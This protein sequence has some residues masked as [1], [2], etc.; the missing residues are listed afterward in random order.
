MN[1]ARQVLKTYFGYDA[2][3]PGQ[4]E[5]IESILAHRDVLAVMPTGA[6]KSL[7]YQI[8]A[9]L[10]E[11]VTVVISP[12]ISLMKDQV[13]ALEA[14][15]IPTTFINSTH[16]LPEIQQRTRGLRQGK[17]RL[18][19][20]APER[21]ESAF[22][23]ELLAS[24]TIPLVAVDEAHCVSQ[25]GHDFRP[26]YMH[27]AASI[28]KLPS[29]PIIAAFTATA[30]DRVKQDIAEGLQ[31]HD[32]LRVTTGYA[33]ENLTF[34]VFRGVDK[35]SFLLDYVR[36]HADESGIIYASTRKEVEEC[37]RYLNQ[38]GLAAGV[39]HAGIEDEARL[40]AQEQFLY[41]RISVMV[42]TNA[43]GMGI[44]KSNVRYVLHY[45]MPRNIESYYQEAGRAGRD[46]DAGDCILLYGPQ[47]VMTQKYIIEQSETDEER[48]KSEYRNLHQM[49]EY[50]HTSHCLQQHIVYYFGDRTA[51]P[52][53]KCSNCT[54]D[55]ETVDVTTEAQKI[56]SC[57]VKMKQRFG[58]TLTAKVLR[59]ANDQKVRQ[60]GLSQLSTYGI[61]S[62]YKEKELVQL[63]QS[64]IVDGYL[65]LSDSAYPVLQITAKAKSVLLSDEK[66]YMKRVVQ[67]VVTQSDYAVVNESLFEELRSLRKTLSQQYRIPPFTIFHDATL[68]EMSERLP[69]SKADM[70]D[71]KGMG[72]V[73]LE[74]YGDDFLE[75]IRRFRQ[76]AP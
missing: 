3:R 33:R 53:G 24:L 55:R 47:D 8:P 46:G 67:P 43:F 28:R 68:R 9:L 37:A 45:N 42:A 31:L 40:E 11:G 56:F 1:Q 65:K 75:I 60:L 57:V 18:L 13:D 2:F 6:G 49:V 66:V 50:C 4:H 32:P 27:I 70:L 10:F 61:L 17:Y 59:G 15:G 63:I 74:K 64:L 25:W 19:Y 73:K 62:T 41:D 51:E 71:I 23:M 29:H 38:H 44:D 22:F 34:Q 12:L 30:T 39:Y 20:I 5:I 58:V 52:C 36:K 21:L 72:T 76:T 26:S 14:A 48:T 16:S 54:D 35:R 7:C 69:V